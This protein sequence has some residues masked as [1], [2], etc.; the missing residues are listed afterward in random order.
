[1]LKLGRATKL[2]QFQLRDTAKRW[3][4]FKSVSGR[5]LKARFST[6]VSAIF[7]GIAA[8]EVLSAPMVAASST[9]APRSW[10]RFPVP[11]RIYRAILP[12]SYGGRIALE[13]LS[14][15]AAYQTTK[16][17]GGPMIWIDTGGAVYQ[18]WLRMYRHS[19]G[20]VNVSQPMAF[21]ALVSRL[22]QQGVAKG[23][24]LYSKAGKS[25]A[26]D[27]CNDASVNIATSLCAT[28]GAIAI[29]RRMVPKATRLGLRELADARGK[30]FGWLLDKIRGR[31]SHHVLGLLS[32]A[33]TNL[34][35]EFVAANAL[36]TQFHK[37]G[38]Y[39]RSLA[40][41][42][43]G[44]IVLGW[45]GHEYHATDAASRFGLRVVAADW[46]SDIPLLSSGGTGLHLSA[47]IAVRPHKAPPVQFNPGKH[48]VTFISS[49]GDNVQWALS[50]FITGRHTW[51]DPLRGKIPFGWSLP[52]E[53]LLQV[54][55]YELN[56]LRTTA[57]PTD[58]FSQFGSGYFYWDHF[59][60]ARD[61]TDALAPVLRRA[62]LFLNRL[63]LHT[64]ISFTVKWNSPSAL[65]AYRLA[66][67]NIPK[68]RALFTIQFD[69]YAAGRGKVIW[70][71][72]ENGPPL[73]VL[74]ALA[75][76]WNMPKNAYAGSPGHVARLLDRWAIKPVRNFGN[77]FTWVVVHAWSRFTEPGHKA[78]LGVYDA[79]AYCAK[80]LNPNIKV[81]TP[82]QLATLLEQS[83]I[84]AKK[85]VMQ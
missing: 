55:P 70:I 74:S 73:P 11:S 44:G 40:L 8:A 6:G 48:Y 7:L 78:K 75:S 82:E 52:L 47:S 46:A 67:L 12:K 42:H 4:N 54:C 16:D 29:D 26:D 41:M 69:P 58:G 43:S 17:G 53:D 62:A 51:S 24:V 37:G 34:R 60:A 83:K 84:V 64:M 33:Q 49:D 20:V 38:G 31:F 2:E 76:I 28:L 21:W 3:D 13:T 77:H 5:R 72:R 45:D 59:G 22:R 23:Y 36:V 66:A 27:K 30:S 35:D 85:T 80:H 32:P 65:A 63:G 39:Q 18:R 68:L 50:G 81:V 25:P 57:K 71:R 1:M 9:V 10:P 19:N 14:G 79:A 56:F 15:L 61:G